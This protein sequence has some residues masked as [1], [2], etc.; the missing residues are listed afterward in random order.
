MCKYRGKLGY[1]EYSKIHRHICAIHRWTREIRGICVATWEYIQY[2]TI[3]G[4]T[5]T[6]LQRRANTRSRVG[7]QTTCAWG[8]VTTRENTCKR[9]EHV[10]SYV[11]HMWEHLRTHG[12]DVSA[13][14][15]SAATHEATWTH[16]HTRKYVQIWGVNTAKASQ[17][18]PKSGEGRLGRGFEHC[19]SR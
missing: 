18:Q 9:V 5:W 19:L 8:Y 7:L 11:G 10:I 17:S 16:G 13:R 14:E 4:I 15:P 2:V 12:N 6:H 3:R 1:M